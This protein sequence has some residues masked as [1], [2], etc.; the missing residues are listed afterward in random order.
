MT[1]ETPGFVHLHV[2]TE[3]SPLDGMTKIADAVA[4]VASEGQIAL[5]ATDHGTTGGAWQLNRL[6]KQAG[7][8]PLIGAEVYLA[9]MTDWRDE[10]DRTQKQIVEV[11]RDDDS[12]VDD[13]DEGSGASAKKKKLYEHLTLFATSK[14]GWTN[15]ASMMDIAEETGFYAHPRIDFKLLKEYSEGILVLTGCLGGPVL[16][17]VSRGNLDQARRNLDR[18]IDAV[19]HD[20]VFME[21]MEHGIE[22]ETR[23]LPAMVALAEEYDLPLVATND[24]HYTFADERE[25]HEAWLA[26]QSKKTLTDPKRFQFHGAGY[27]LRTE[28]E[29]RALRPEAW[30][31]TACDNTIVVANRFDDDVL[32]EAKIRLP[33]F[34]IPDTFLANP[35]SNKSVERQ[36][37]TSLAKLGSEKRYGPV[38]PQAVKDRLNTELSIIDD[39]GFVSYFLMVW[40]LIKWAREDGNLPDWEHLEGGIL[41][42][43]GRGSAAGS[44][45]SYVLEIVDICPLE[46]NLLF[47]RFMERGRIDM[48]DI[49]IDFEQQHLER[50]QAYLAYR[51]GPDKVARI[52]THNVA[53][54]KA[55]IKDA[56]R[57]LEL[58]AI[59]A[60]LTKVVPAGVGGNVFS[61]AD[62][63]DV[64]NSTSE[65]YRAE[66][67]LCGADGVRVVNLAKKMFGTLKGEGI[68]ACG[69]II[70]TEPLRGLIP[71]RRDRTKVGQGGL[72]MVTAWDAP[73]VGDTTGNTPG[74]G[75][76]KL[77]VLSIRNLDIVS[78]ACKFIK[79][80][81]GETIDPRKLPHPNTKGDPRVQKTWAL[82]KAGRTAGVFQMDSGGMQNMARAIG[83]ESL[84][85]LSAIVALFRPGPLS[86]GMDQLYAQRKSG[87]MAVDYDQFTHDPAEQAAIATV[88]G[89]TY[90]VWVFQE[91]LMRLGAVVAGF[92]AGLRAKLRKAVGKK[93]KKVM[94]AVSLLFAE[95]AVKEFRDAE[96]NVTSIKFAEETATKIIL[97][98]QGSAAY[99][100]NASHSAAYAQLAFITAFL[101]ANWPAEYGAAILATT[102]DSDKRLSAIDALTDEGITILAPDVN[103][104]LRITAPAGDMTVRLG[105]TEIKSV[106]QL[107]DMVVEARERNGNIPF[108]SLESMLTRLTDVR[109]NKAPSISAIEG[110]IESGACDQF[111]PRLGQLMVVRAMKSNPALAVPDAEFGVLE[112]SMRQRAR[113][114][115]SLGMHP[116]K[117]LRHEVSMFVM[118]GSSLQG[119]QIVGPKVAP[120]SQIPDRNGAIVFVGALLGQW[121]EKGYAGGRMAS[122]TLEGSKGR[123][124]GV[125]WDDVLKGVS[126]VPRVGA[127]VAVHAIVSMREREIEDE[128]GNIIETLVTK[129]LTIKRI[130]E[131]FVDDSP[132][133]SFARANAEH[134]EDDEPLPEVPVLPLL[135][136]PTK[137]AAAKAAGDSGKPPT[138]PSRGGAKKASSPAVAPAEADADAD[139]EPEPDAEPDT[140]PSAEPVVD[141][142]PATEYDDY[143]PFDDSEYPPF[144][145]QMA[146]PEDYAPPAE[147]L[148]VLAPTVDVADAPIPVIVPDTRPQDE[149]DD[150]DAVYSL[151]KLARPVQYAVA[152]DPKPVLKVK[153]VPKGRTFMGGLSY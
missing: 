107:G 89:E 36:Y 4:K 81:T 90:G 68:H 10:P 132:V 144:D 70:S 138:A 65:K 139:S 58:P 96:G 38:M 113:L 44:V 64:T 119:G 85:D 43:P 59:G 118:P 61:F 42:G 124:S 140:Q 134:E 125:M 37:I 1:S 14:V 114:G 152:P 137:A 60:K 146:P 95:G 16:G 99:L 54:T 52:G 100:F 35:A 26:V 104:S 87:A 130:W 83:P 101:K 51:W 127:T 151:L 94:D 5:A 18:I 135:K 92:D 143:S 23:A 141:V 122:I 19:G 27:H 11:D 6:A 50:V 145:D 76:L 46:N 20:N 21:I 17:P 129:E 7:I 71:L 112:R 41:V 72:T 117:S 109:E 102:D 91:Q 77:D 147:A 53:Q 34:P 55:A 126:A 74:I 115:V 63:E 78:Q 13:D 15:L 111:G 131:I 62:L 39:A 45:L 142:P 48:P 12:A 123:I 3:Y 121:A 47:E 106:G 110:L 67:A 40:D 66:L 2:H 29:M 56:A 28:A 86:E 88:L 150:D 73:D 32:P 116:L 128:D 82:L 49:D 103:S 75:L 69:V 33:G 80:T 133:G 79:E 8:K 120:L 84:T 98:M 105:L 153:R 25:A 148:T 57:V 31:Q 9:V 22:S 30:W 149:I 24:S 136:L 97:A 108:T 93:D